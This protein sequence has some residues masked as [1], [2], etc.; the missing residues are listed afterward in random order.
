MVTGSVREARAVD[1]LGNITEIPSPPPHKAEFSPQDKAAGRR[2]A[3][4][5][6]QRV[7]AKMQPKGR[8][9]A[10]CWKNIASVI[11]IMKHPETKNTHYG[12]GLMKCG[13]VWVCPVCSAKITEK[14]RLKIKEGLD[15][16]QGRG[17]V[18]MITFTLQHTKDDKLADLAGD[19]RKVITQFK[20]GAGWNRLRAKYKLVGDI[21]S[22]ENT[23]SKEHGW[24]PHFHFLYFSELQSIDVKAMQKDFSARYTMLLEKAG[25]YASAIHGVDVR[26]GDQAIG[27]YIAKMG[28]EVKP[29]EK[30]SKAQVTSGLDYEMA[31]SANKTGRMGDDGII[32]YSPFDLLELIKTGDDWAAVAFNEYAKAM[33]RVNQLNWSHGLKEL[34]G[35]GDEVDATDK[36]IASGA[37]DKGGKLFYGL[38]SKDWP[39][40]R[41]DAKK[42]TRVGLIVEVA[43][44]LEV[45]QYESYINLILQESKRRAEAQEESQHETKYT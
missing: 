32:H 35:V 9:A 24:H 12:K 26:S 38:Q 7:A 45:E 30:K 16:W 14:R 6:L 36:D 3:R 2:V 20:S 10:C 25:R 8:V 33:Y 23:V 18:A 22:I 44:G 42:Q 39:Y 5:D 11:E 15:K 27:D 31:Y 19:Q 21:R 17:T 40:L 13:M 28:M 4:Y 29:Q 41:I 37:L 1:S 43:R 34:L